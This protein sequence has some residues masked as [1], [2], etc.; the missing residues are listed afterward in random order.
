MASAH[1]E[2]QGREIG[3]SCWER[4]RQVA[5]K[6]NLSLFLKGRGV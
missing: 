1:T 5:E 3:F 2:E 6:A 4:L